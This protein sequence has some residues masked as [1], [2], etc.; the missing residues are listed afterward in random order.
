MPNR[1]AP[2]E[3]KRGNEVNISHFYFVRHGQTVWNVEN[4]ICGA[5][6]SPLTDKG[7]EQA[8]VTGR[9]LRDKIDHGEI[10]IDEILTSPLSRAYDTAV[11]ISRIIQVP[12][13]AEPRLT[14]QNFGKWEGTA[15][16][17]AEFAKAKE[18]FVDSYGGGESMMRLA[19]RIYNLIDDIRKE[20]EKTYLLVAHNGISRMIESYFRDMSNEEFA[21]FGIKN[22][23]V[24]EYQF[25]GIVPDCRA[26][27]DLLCRRLQSL[28]EGVA[29]DVTILSNASAL[30]YQ[31]LP[32]LNWAGFYMASGDEL[33]L[34]PF[35]GKTA[36][37]RI[38][39]GRGVCGA[40]AEKDRTVVVENI[41][42]FAGHIACDRDSR[43]EIV[44]PVHLDG[45]LY[46]VLDV[47]SPVLNRF[48]SAD[49]EGL[50]RFVSVLEEGLISE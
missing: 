40:A 25:D 10:H 20:P 45:R 41:H 3:A 42:E 46:G 37:V 1:S 34:G 48:R 30:L 50:E 17:G 16:N 4:K 15:R 43:S 9:I 36:C 31:T 49:R 23:E 24:V 14:E 7:H 2:E 32:K 22:A 38:P 33:M 26:D 6:E 28:M 47:D 39:R 12:V 21:A 8:R 29:S 35:Q 27:Y 44:I 5:T 18:N 19:Q 13:Q 11:E